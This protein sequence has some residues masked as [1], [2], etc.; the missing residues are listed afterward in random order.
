[1]GLLRARQQVARLSRL[2]RNLLDVS[3]ISANE[4]KLR[5]S[6]VD[7][8]ATT[9]EVIEQFGLEL[10]RVGCSL[11]LDATGPVV[12]RWDALRL[13]QVVTNLLSN[14]CKYAAGKPIDIA[15]EARGD[16]ACL[17]VRDQGSGIASADIDR[18]FGRFERA[19]SVRHHGGLGLGLYIT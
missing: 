15:V 1:N 4:L 17:T 5:L 9:R 10:S 16:I 6:D 14:A 7:L 13:A 2:V 8:C 11:R 12:G 3:C 18:I 19:A